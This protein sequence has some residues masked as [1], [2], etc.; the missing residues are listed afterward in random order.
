MS[1]RAV[2]PDLNKLNP[3]ESKALILS[4]HEQLCSIP[5]SHSSLTN[6]PHLPSWKRL[7]K[8]RTRFIARLRPFAGGCRN[9]KRIVAA[10]RKGRAVARAIRRLQPR[11]PLTSRNGMSHPVFP[12]ADEFESASESAW[13]FDR[14][15]YYITHI[16]SLR[17]NFTEEDAKPHKILTGPNLVKKIALCLHEEIE[18]IRAKQRP[19]QALS[20]QNLGEA[21]GEA[22]ASGI[23]ER[24]LQGEAA[25]TPSRIP[26]YY[27]LGILD[28]FVGK[29]SK[30]PDDPT[31]RLGP[32]MTQEFKKI[33]KDALELERGLVSQVRTRAESLLEEL[34]KSDFGVAEEP[35]PGS[36]S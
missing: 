8:R 28:E 18:K 7:R 21:S 35:S 13:D 32:S 24:M 2:L 33:L 20:T 5:N 17:Q 10:T 23:S 4:Q 36:R 6:R 25:D 19:K 1:V 11:T 30:S 12:D 22:I 14:V 9:S 29:R 15:V 27:V 3:A 31:H 26:L 16:E 34:C